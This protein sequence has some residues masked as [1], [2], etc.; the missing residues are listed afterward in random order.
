MFGSS[1]DSLV[2]RNHQ[3]SDKG[4]WTHPITVVGLMLSG[5]AFF[6]Y[7]YVVAKYAVNMPFWDDYD[8]LYFLNRFLSGKG[9]LYKM[10][11]LFSQ[12]NEHRIVFT[13]IV[14]LLDYYAFGKINFIHVILVGDIGLLLIVLLLCLYLV[15]SRVRPLNLAVVAVTMFS[16]SQHDSMIWA[17][18]SLQQYYELFFALAALFFF[19][20][21]SNTGDFVAGLCLATFASF[22]Q[23]SGLIVFPLM[24]LYFAISGDLK[25]VS[26]IAL[27]GTGIFYVYFVLLHYNMTSW[28][29]ASKMYALR[30]PLTYIKFV[31]IFMGNLMPGVHSYFLY[32]PFFTGV[33]F[34]I[35]AIYMGTQYVADK[36]E[37]FLFFSMLFVLATAAA[38]GLSRISWGI[39]EA[40]A[41]RYSIYSLLLL[42]IVFSYYAIGYQGNRPALLRLHIFGLIFPT[43]IF[44]VWLNTGITY[45]KYMSFAANHYIAYNPPD[46]DQG[47]NILSESRKLHIFVPD[48]M[49]ISATHNGMLPN[50]PLPN[51]IAQIALLPR[52]DY[53]TD[54]SVDSINNYDA[55]FGHQDEAIVL[56]SNTITITGWAIDE[57]ERA[58][59]SAVFA[60]I[61]GQLF[62]LTYGIE[63]PGVASAFKNSG[64]EYAGFYGRIVARNLRPGTNTLSL[65]IIDTK[66]TGYYQTRPLRLLLR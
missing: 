1:K 57:K 63:R 16:F 45:I 56:Q 20:R 32:L 31:L 2:N 15:K 58:L 41:S 51:S 37:P 39:E 5:A 28:G 29:T 18:A 53:H 12:D 40:T 52:N 54:F 61:D 48:H 22:T 26:I 3:E 23:A 21:S 64:Y 33:I 47:P 66:E 49:L 60:D 42:A 55:P 11:L 17:A 7:W 65:R 13:R 9:F 38:A 43:I 6:S 25:R 59:A 44:C 62:P 50:A 46:P 35:F 4:H 19:T 36:R 10:H 14:E 30:H 24:L 8:A 27:Y 34:L